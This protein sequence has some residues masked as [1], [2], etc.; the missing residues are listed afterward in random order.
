MVAPAFLILGLLLIFV[1]MLLERQRRR[2]GKTSV[3]PR[4]PRVDLNDPAQRNTFAF[5]VSSALV[6][7]LISAMGSYRSYE[8]TDSVQ[9]CGQT[10]H[11]IMQS[12]VHHLSSVAACQGCLCSVPRLARGWM[13]CA[14]QALWFLSGLCGH[15][16]QVPAADT[17]A[18]ANLRPAQQT[19]EQCHWPRKFYGAQLKVFYH[20]TEDEQNTP[21][22][23][24]M[25][26][27]T[28]GAEPNTG[29]PSG[30]HWHVLKTA[31]STLPLMRNI[32]SFRGCN[33]AT[34]KVGQRS[35]R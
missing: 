6:F 18:V 22:Q 20:Y 19:C 21:R 32:R 9:F 29:I 13:V 1:G 30:I 2:K 27:N 11:T 31:S 26:I 23:I 34:S 10:C 33:L 7:V 28:G 15:L 5:F 24:R 14:L 8:F 25:L 17:N 4:F 12:R 35:T 16:S 3:I